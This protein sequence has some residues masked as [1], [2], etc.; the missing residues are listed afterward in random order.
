MTN[1][2]NALL[3]LGKK[4]KKAKTLLSE[5]EEVFETKLRDLGKQLFQEGKNLDKKQTL[6]N[7]GDSES[8]AESEGK[9]IARTSDKLK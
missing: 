9:M 1:N 6:C 5:Y 4:Y 2:L 3:K 7:K 8:E